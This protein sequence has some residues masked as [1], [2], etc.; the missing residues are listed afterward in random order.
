MNADIHLVYVTFPD[1]ETARR[2][3]RLLIDQRLA[4]CANLYGPGQSI[5]RWEGEVQQESEFVVILKT[6]AARIS[7]LK[8]TVLDEHPYDVPCMVHWP[9]EDGTPAFLDWVRSE[10]LPK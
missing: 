10:T 4:A 5:Y 2:I 3:A 1:E 7:E 9:I 6:T 8:K